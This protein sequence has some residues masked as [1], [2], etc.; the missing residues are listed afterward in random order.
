MERRIDR[1]AFQ[2]IE[3]PSR[4]KLPCSPPRPRTGA[5]TLRKKVD[6]TSLVMLLYPL[7]NL[8]VILPLSIY[9]ISSLAGLKASSQALAVCG[10]I[11][12]LGGFANVMLYSFTRVGDLLCPDHEL[13]MYAEYRDDFQASTYRECHGRAPNYA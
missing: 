1:T 2:P 11:F 3:I 9:R 12:A 13:T 7:V 5:S 4:D 8:M 10:A 6:R